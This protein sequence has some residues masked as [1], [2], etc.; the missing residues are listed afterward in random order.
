LDYGTDEYVIEAYSGND[1]AKVEVI[2]DIPK[3]ETT[4]SSTEKTNDTQT[5]INSS[6]NVSNVDASGINGLILTKV[7]PDLSLGTSDEL[8]SFLIEN[9]NYYFYWNSLRPIKNNV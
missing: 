4:T 5:N 9:T 1:V 7:E 3:K 6:Q 8:N 2:I